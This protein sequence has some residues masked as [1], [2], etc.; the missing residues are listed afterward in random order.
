MDSKVR[1]GVKEAREELVTMLAGDELRDAVR[2][3]F[4]SKQVCAPVRPGHAGWEVGRG[5]P[6]GPLTR[7][8]R[9]SPTRTSLRP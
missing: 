7:G 3:V 5:G 4:A 8:R 2:L 9:A 6:R 1:E